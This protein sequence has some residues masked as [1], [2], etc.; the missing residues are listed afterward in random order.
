MK[1][2]GSPKEGRGW[3]AKECRQSRLIVWHIVNFCRSSE[4]WT[5]KMV[6][7]IGWKIG[8]H[9]CTY[10]RALSLAQIEKCSEHNVSIKQ[11]FDA[12]KVFAYP[13]IRYIFKLS[14]NGYVHNLINAF[15]LKF[16]FQPI[17]LW[18]P[19]VFHCISS[20]FSWE[21]N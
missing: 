21:P 4:K 5:G 1:A 11:S 17:N 7:K 13:T 19:S 20:L 9:M 18:Q 10:M 2:G 16:H 14:N 15:K 6:R 3:L 12:T 8:W